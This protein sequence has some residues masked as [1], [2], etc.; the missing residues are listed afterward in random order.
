LKTTVVVIR[1]P[2][3]VLHKIDEQ[4]KKENRSR[5]NMIQTIVKDKYEKEED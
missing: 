1:L 3:S 5:A 4:A 2:D